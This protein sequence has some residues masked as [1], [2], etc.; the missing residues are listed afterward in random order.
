MN[1]G[2][3]WFT[4]TSQGQIRLPQLQGFGPMLREGLDKEGVWGYGIRRIIVKGQDDICPF[5]FSA[6]GYKA[7][8]GDWSIGLRAHTGRSSSIKFQQWKDGDNIVLILT[9][10]MSQYM[11]EKGY[12]G[13][14]GQLV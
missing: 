7:R 3:K 9:S 2:P 13:H 8:E 6:M 1:A 11:S 4:Y 14:Y 12:T 5:T 10:L